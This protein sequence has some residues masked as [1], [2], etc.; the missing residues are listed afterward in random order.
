MPEMVAVTNTTRFGESKNTLVDPWAPGLLGQALLK[1]SR[2]LTSFSV[3]G[4]D[5]S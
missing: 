1:I 2:S 4:R 3:F 5:E